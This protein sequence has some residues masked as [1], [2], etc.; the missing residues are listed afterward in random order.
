MPL[1]LTIAVIFVLLLT[2]E[3]I[4][5]RQ[6]VHN[7]FSR[8]FIHITVGSFVAFWPLFLSWDQIKLL[9]LAFIIIVLISRQLKVFQA[10]HSVQRPTQGEL[11]FA[12]AVGATA[13]ITENEWIYMAAILQMSL[14]DGL[15]AIIGTRFGNSNR[16]TVFGNPKSLYG[17]LT[18][19]IVSLAIL[20]AFVSYSGSALTIA[21][22]AAMACVASLIENVGLE[23]T[24]NLLVPIFIATILTIAT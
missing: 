13:I 3:I 12:V 11:F 23:G 7:E 15:A 22:L 16:Y 6:H 17:T 2:N 9:S 1:I 4:W 5:R 20:L 18:F 21:S 14:A 8:K 24:D 10:I 19:F